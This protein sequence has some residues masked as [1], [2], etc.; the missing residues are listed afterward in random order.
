MPNYAK[1][2][3]DYETSVSYLALSARET[4]C[5]GVDAR[6]AFQASAAAE[7]GNALRAGASN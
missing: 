7:S 4:A 1:T 6:P 3:D 2:R 5:S